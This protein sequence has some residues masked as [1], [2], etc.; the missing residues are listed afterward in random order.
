[1]SIESVTVASIMTRMV[2]TATEDHNIKQVAKI[3]RESDVGSVVIVKASA[4]SRP[5]GMITERDIVRLIGDDQ[6]ATLQMSAGEVMSHP[7]ITIGANALIRDAM[8]TMQLRNIRRLPVVDR[9]ENMI[10][11]ITERDIFKAIL[12]S[13]A[14][15]ASFCESLTV[16]YRPIYER[17][18]EFVLGEM[19]PPERGPG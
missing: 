13:Q 12:S 8:Q 3:M 10:G 1:M 5:A 17:L 16:E 9:E 7:I 6:V 2:K 4:P 14:L 19:T 15:I 18:S 11:I